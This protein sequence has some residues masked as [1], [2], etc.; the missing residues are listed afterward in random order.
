MSLPAGWY[1]WNTDASKKKAMKSWSISYRCSKKEGKIIKS[2][3]HIIKDCH[4]LVPETPAAR[5]SKTAANMVMRRI[6]VESNSLNTINSIMGQQKTPAH[7]A[8]LVEDIF[9]TSRDWMNIYYSYCNRK[10][11]SLADSLER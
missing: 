5:A 10:A 4:I 2:V 6:I 9:S 11:N 3:W 8:S 7:I 1:K